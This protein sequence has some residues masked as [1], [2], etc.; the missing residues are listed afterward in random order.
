MLWAIKANCE[1]ETEGRNM[2]TLQPSE[3]FRL[4]LVNKSVFL[5][6]QGYFC[7]TSLQFKLGRA[8]VV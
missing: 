6:S 8:N 4:P 7:F 3:R 5:F 2:Q 1:G